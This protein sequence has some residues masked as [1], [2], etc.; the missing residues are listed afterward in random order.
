MGEIDTQRVYNTLFPYYIEACAVTQYHKRGEAPGGWGGHAAIFMNGAE[1]DPGAGYPRL[2]LAAAA[3]DLSP[4]DSG[5]GVSVNRIFTNANWVAIPGRQEFFRGG[6][7]AGEILDESLYESAVRRAAAAG[8]FSGIAIRD[9][10]GRRKPQGMPL[11]EFVVRH[12][13]GTDFAMNFARTA[14]SARLPLRREALGQVIGYLNAVNESARTSGYTWDAY[15]NNCSHVAHN[16]VAAAGVWD[17]K[18]ARASG[19]MNVAMDVAS[20]VRAIALRRMSDF[21]FPAN[22]FVRLYE[23]G[24]ERPIDDALDAFRNHDIVRTINDGWLS[25]GPGALI[26]T[27]PMHDAG[28]NRLFTAG[29]DPFLFSV[30]MLWDKEQKFRALTRTPPANGTD[31]YTNLTHFR[32]RYSAALARG[33]VRERDGDADHGDTDGEGFAIF[34]DRFREQLAEDLRRTESLISEYRL[35]AGVAAG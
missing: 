29:R 30:P 21:S 32:D 26:A 15:T 35:L 13:I 12:S 7:P 25:T 18:E 24:N 19:P 6:L 1:I 10:L 8:W 16:A 11:Q 31:L 17:S 22:T 33:P 14:Y 34:A 4:P 28:M 27:Y 5:V 2:R 23:A 9:E 3:T 20:V